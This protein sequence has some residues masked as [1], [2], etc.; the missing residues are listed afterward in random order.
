LGNSCLGDSWAADGFCGVLRGGDSFF[1]TVALNVTM[2][3]L[4]FIV[5]YRICIDFACNLSYDR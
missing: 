1:V 2:I 3:R 5:Y 4:L